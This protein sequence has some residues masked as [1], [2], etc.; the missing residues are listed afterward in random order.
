M[1]GLKIENDISFKT[2]LANYGWKPKDRFE[3]LLEWIQNRGEGEEMKRLSTYHTVFGDYT[4]DE[5]FG[6]GDRLVNDKRGFS[7]ILDPM[8]NYINRHA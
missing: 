2:A 1:D 7:S 3:K 6:N 8:V 5:V 4:S